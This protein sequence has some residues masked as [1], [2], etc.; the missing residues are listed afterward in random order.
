MQEK[1]LTEAASKLSECQ[2]TIASL[3]QQ[4]KS[5]TNIDEFMFEAKKPEK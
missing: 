1:E 2:K 3:G 5:L 4:L